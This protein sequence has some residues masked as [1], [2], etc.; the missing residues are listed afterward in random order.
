MRNCKRICSAQ[1]LLNLGKGI[2]S[3][4]SNFLLFEI[5]IRKLFSPEIKRSF[6]FIQSLYYVLIHN[7]IHNNLLSSPLNQS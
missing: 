1:E 3:T 7:T 2:I 6:N 4:S 5:E